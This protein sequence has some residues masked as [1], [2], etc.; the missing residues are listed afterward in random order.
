MD[1][2]HRYAP[3]GCG[4]NSPRG[5]FVTSAGHMVQ[6]SAAMNWKFT[7]KMCVCVDVDVCVDIQR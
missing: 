2:M 4:L 3:H 1:R 6:D 5:G 7:P